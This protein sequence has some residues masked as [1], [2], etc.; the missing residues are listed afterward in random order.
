MIGADLEC[1][2]LVALD[3]TTAADLAPLREA[4]VGETGLAIR[5]AVLPIRVEKGLW[6]PDPDDEAMA[7]IL[8]VR[9]YGETS[10]EA[11][12]PGQTL[13]GGEIIDLIAFSVAFPE[14]WALRTGN[15]TWLGSIEPQF[16]MPDPVP[17]W[18]TPLHWL[19]NGCLGLVLLSRDRRDRYRVLT[20]C[21]SIL[22]EDERHADELRQLLQHPWLAPPV[23]VRRGRE[24]RNAA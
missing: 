5:P 15:A 19:G 23:L 1:E 6:H 16:L 11:P 8:P 18:R 7:F 12:E 20:V 14:R 9:V 4:G 3:H 2:Y 10:P 22:A 21:D 13:C 24:V 17:I